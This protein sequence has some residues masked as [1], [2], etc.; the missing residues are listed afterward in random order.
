MYRYKRLFPEADTSIIKDVEFNRYLQIAIDNCKNPYALSYLTHM[1]EAW[2][3]YGNEGVKMQLM[4]A[5][6]NMEGWRGSVA[7]E[8]KE[9]FKMIIK[10]IK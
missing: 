7:K 4:Y 6:N 5:L 2:S 10:R 1:I 8:T 9:Y 3:E